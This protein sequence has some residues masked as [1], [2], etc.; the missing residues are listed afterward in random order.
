M[1]LYNDDNI[2]L[3]QYYYLAACCISS[4]RGFREESL[5]YT[6]QYNIIII[7]IM[8]VCVCGGTADE[9][10]QRTPGRLA[11]RSVVGRTKLPFHRFRLRIND[12]LAYK[13]TVM[14]GRMSLALGP[15]QL[16]TPPSSADTPV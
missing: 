4:R 14:S 8:C 12:E 5:V 16:K 1:I 15:G 2:A 10:L 7:C 13:V 6:L 11:G 3:K 9:A